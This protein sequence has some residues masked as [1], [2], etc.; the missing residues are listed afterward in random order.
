MKYIN[1]NFGHKEGDFAIAKVAQVMMEAC[2]QGSLFTRF[3][4]DEMLAVC[5]GVWSEEQVKE[6]FYAS[7]K[8]FNDSAEKEY[9]ILAS[10]GIYITQPEDDLSFEGIV[11][12]A[13][14][15][16]YM[17]KAKRKKSRMR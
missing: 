6:D 13:D 3:G 17:E 14:I 7:L 15:L 16:M 1:D 11:E 4:G 2:P 10:M 9:A 8:K 12:K 5:P